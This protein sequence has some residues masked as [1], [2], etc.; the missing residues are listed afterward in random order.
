MIGVYSSQEAAEAAVERMR[1]L[2]G[3]CATPEGF[4]SDRY[5]VDEDNC[6]SGYIT[7]PRGYIGSREPD[8]PE[9]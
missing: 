6:T 4:C 5:A 9:T 7:V 8:P 1:L 2:P 3:F